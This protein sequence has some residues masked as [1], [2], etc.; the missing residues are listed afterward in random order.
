M[1]HWTLNKKFKFKFKSVEARV[2]ID[3]PWYG[4]KHVSINPLALA[5][6][7]IQA[8]TTGLSQFP[9]AGLS[10]YVSS[11]SHPEN[12]GVAFSRRF[13]HP[14]IPGGAFL[15]LLSTPKSP[16]ELFSSFYPII[17]KPVLF[18]FFSFFFFLFKQILL[19]MVKG[20]FASESRTLYS[21]G[22]ANFTG[23]S[24]PVVGYVIDI[25]SQIR[26]LIL[27]DLSVTV[28]YREIVGCPCSYRWLLKSQQL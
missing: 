18:S 24:E 17:L 5:T 4:G 7:S 6:R 9:A 20:V 28:A 19:I 16:E 11:F 25:M 21:S 8:C 12:P 23:T 13:I 2:A 27:S 1:V 10:H 26:V 22:W 14:E 3:E 15:V